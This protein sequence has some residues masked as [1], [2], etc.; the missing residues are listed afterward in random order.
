MGTAE[1]KLRR[2]K[3]SARYL[4][5]QN[6][7]RP[8]SNVAIIGGGLAGLSAAYHLLAENSNIEI[9]IYDKANVGEGGASSVAGGLLHP[10]S[11]RGK[12]I[13]FGLSALDHS[14]HLIHE[15]AK[16]QPQCILRHQIYRVAL[17][18]KNVAHLQDTAQQYSTLAAWMSKEEMDSRFGIDSLGGLELRNGCKVINVPSYLKGLWEVCDAKGSIQWELVQLPTHEQQRI[19]KDSI[20]EFGDIYSFNKHLAQHDAVIL[21]AGAGILHDQLISSKD[22]ELPV[23]LVRGQSVEMTLPKPEDPCNDA[24]SNNEAL[25]CGKYISPLPSD[26]SSRRFVIGATHEFKDEAL[27]KTEVIEELKSRSYP[28]AKNLWDDGKVDRLTTGV[29]MQSNRG[30]F[31]RMPIIGRYDNANKSGISHK[32][33]WFFTGLSSRGLIHHGIFGKWLAS[34]VL[35]DNE[36]E[37]RSQFAEFDWWQKK[38]KRQS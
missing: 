11:P 1:I 14:N 37:L 3:T 34:A 19:E 6:D 20:N 15:A 22:C 16:H 2:E 27:S 25:L 26:S 8:I 30:S 10:F 31:G 38:S 9:T 29:R 4:S 23:H 21:S 17:N 12:L 18:T 24:I 7:P 33:A 5:N 32:N 28:F 35:H 13:H 36:E